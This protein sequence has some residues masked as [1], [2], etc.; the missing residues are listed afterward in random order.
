MAEP[1]LQGKRAVREG[2]LINLKACHVSPSC[3]KSKL[4]ILQ[5]RLRFMK[6]H[7]LISF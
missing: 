3:N 6:V 5:S 7:R 1:S 2:Y 4:R